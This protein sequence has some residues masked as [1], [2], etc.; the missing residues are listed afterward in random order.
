MA[1]PPI[2]TPTRLRSR[3]ERRQR[4]LTATRAVRETIVSLAGLVGRPV[5]LFDNKEVGVLVD[6]VARFSGDQDYPPVT[7]LVIRVGRR[8]VFL[9][10]GFVSALAATE[11]VLRTTSVDLRDFVRRPGEV[12]LA[13][14][15][16]DHQVVDVD[17]VQ[18]VRASDLYLAPVQGRIRLV[19]VDVSVHALLRRLGPVR[20]RARPTPERVID[21]A[22]IQPLGDA[23]SEVRL[24]MS[25]EGIHRLRPGE[26]ADLLE[27]LGREARHELLEVLDPEDAADA[28]EEMEPG[29]LEALLRTTEPERAAEL[30]ATM[31]TDEAVDALR[32]LAG[33]ER[34]EILAEMP[35]ERA[36]ELTSLLAYDEHSAGGIMTT[37]LAVI[38]ADETVAS[39]EQRLVELAEHRGEIDAVVVVDASGALVGDVPL[40]DLLIADHARRIGE[41]CEDEA[42]VT[43]APDTSLRDV[44]VALIESRRSSV[45]VLDGDRPVGRILAD[46]V[47][48]ALLPERGRLHF[49][50]LLQ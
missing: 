12:L 7:G 3:R 49:P 23:A 4:R 46:D 32:D 21:W 36:E 45:L 15:L 20:F 30:I 11:V 35:A 33:D 48:D 31:E 26:L 39:A 43:A 5:R 47:V 22:A 34:A 28:L 2:P 40:F 42:P 18:V 1:R 38:D 17:G 27:D 6:L 50:R 25:H 24:R 8:E 9:E 13:R 14:D 41:L 19:G 10:A 29:E 37:L 16:L 44:A